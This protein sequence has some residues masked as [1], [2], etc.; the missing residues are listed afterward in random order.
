[1]RFQRAN[2]FC[3]AA[4]L[5]SASWGC[6]RSSTLLEEPK[7]EAFPLAADTMVRARWAGKQS[8]AVSASAYSFMRLWEL[9]ESQQLQG[10]FLSR[11]AGS[12]ERSLTTAALEAQNEALASLMSDLVDREWYL[13]MREPTNQ[14]AQFVFAIRLD[15]RRAETWRVN[16]ARALSSTTGVHPTMRPQSWSLKHPRSQ[17]D[18]E[19][20][21]VGEWSVV[22]VA[23]QNNPLFEQTLARIKELRQPGGWID[24]E[25]WLELDIDLGRLNT[26]R[27]A[28]AG[29]LPRLSLSISGDGAHV[30]TDATLEFAYSLPINPSPWRFPNQL[31]RDPIVGFTALRGLDPWLQT[32]AARAGLQKFPA[33]DQ[34]FFWADSAAPLQ[35][36]FAASLTDTVATQAFLARSMPEG[37]GWLATNGIGQLAELSNGSGMLWQGLPVI[38]PFVKVTQHDTGTWAE[39]GLVAVP[40][41]NDVSLPA[42]VYPRPSVQSLVGDMQKRTNLMAFSWETTGSRV[43]SFYLLSQVLRVARLHPQLPQEAPSSKWIQ[44]V[45]QRLGNAT[46]TVTLT[47]SNQLTLERQSATG[48]TAAELHLLSDWVESPDFPSG[49]YSTRTRRAASAAEFQKAP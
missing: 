37:N 15:T 38:S 29:Q 34:C 48:F 39:G 6:Q 8:L 7:V 36:H 11:L 21:R 32:A 25:H 46:T 30:L 17:H 40:A 33:F 14:P 26:G 5:L 41:T 2:F 45:R 31:V 4:L 13:E 19:F 43:E 42:P 1:M 9:P 35:M 16:L 23:Q 3:V 28:E 10:Y 20:D 12:L 18:I 44:A 49:L 27:F 22:G 24:P 47:A